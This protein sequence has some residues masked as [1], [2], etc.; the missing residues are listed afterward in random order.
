MEFRETKSVTEN[1]FLGD[2]EHI[3]LKTHHTHEFYKMSTLLCREAH[4][5]AHGKKRDPEQRN[6]EKTGLLSSVRKAGTAHLRST[7]GQ[8]M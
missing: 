1:E 4:D 6:R 7:S 2:V 8:G 3:L 5:K